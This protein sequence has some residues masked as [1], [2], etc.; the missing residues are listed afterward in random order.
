MDANEHEL[1]PQPRMTQISLRTMNATRPLHAHSPC[2][3]QV[4]YSRS[5]VSVRG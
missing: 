5:F 4:P 3:H 1:K 2:G